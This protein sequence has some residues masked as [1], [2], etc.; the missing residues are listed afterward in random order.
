MSNSSDESDKDDS[1]INIGRSHNLQ[2]HSSHMVLDEVVKRNN[3]TWDPQNI[4]KFI[5]IY[6]SYIENEDQIGLFS[7]EIF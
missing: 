7:F 5:Q 3:S 1:G 6:D 4:E 2:G